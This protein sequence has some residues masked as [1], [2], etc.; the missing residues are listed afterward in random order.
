MYLTLAPRLSNRGEVSRLYL[1]P[2]RL[3]ACNF[4]PNPVLAPNFVSSF[5]PK[6]K[7]HEKRTSYD[8][9]LLQGRRNMVH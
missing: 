5:Q 3:Q 2:L 1:F 4:R 6:H 7:R 9:P 8:T